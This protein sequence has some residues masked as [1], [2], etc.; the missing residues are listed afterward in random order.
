LYQKDV[1]LPKKNPQIA[2]FI[3]FLAA[4]GH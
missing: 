4:S 3:R 1:L 2:G